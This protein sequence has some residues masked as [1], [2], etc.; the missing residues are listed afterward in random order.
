MFKRNRKFMGLVLALLM[1]FTIVL[2]SMTFAD[3]EEMTITVLGTTDVHGNIYNWSYEDG[4]EIDNKG[5]AKLYSIVKE[6]REEIGRASC[7]ERV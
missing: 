4:K 3:A 2:P 1:V 7:R 5:F 6:I